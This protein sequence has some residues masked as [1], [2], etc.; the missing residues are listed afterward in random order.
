MKSGFVLTVAVTNPLLLASSST[1]LM[2]AAS[3]L[4][5]MLGCGSSKPLSNRYTFEDKT[6]F[7][8]I[9]KL[10]KNPNDKQSAELLPEAYQAALDKR[11]ETIITEK[12]T[13]SIGDRWME[14]AKEREVT[15]QMYNAIKASPAASKVIPNPHD[16]SAGIQKAKE[17]AAEEYYNQGLENLNYNNRQ[18]AIQA[19]DLFVKADKAVPGYK[20]VKLLSQQALEIGTIKVVVKPVNY[21]RYGWDY[22]GFQNDWL[23]QQMV[24]DLNFGSY[25]DV[26]FFTD[27]EAS[28]KQIRADRIVDLDFT[29]LF[30][31]QVYRDNYTINRSKKIQTG[32]TKTQPPQPVYTTVYAT[33]YVNRQYLESNA[34]LECRIYDWAT[35][36][37]ILY[38]RFPDRYTWKVETATY[39]GDQRA[40]EP[41]DWALINNRGNDYPPGRNQIAERLMRNSY[42]MLLNR[43]RSGVSF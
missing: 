34:T 42:N 11:R 28:S 41:S 1:A 16:P 24:R 14:I 6:V 21:N 18:H 15:L 39:R 2:V 8:L 3:F 20:D 17:R 31:G 37:N 13:G 23:Q 25:R 19:Y 7:E 29:Q 27:W 32:S 12:N 43:I 30:I 4:F 33:V 35:G 5:S 36:R 38:D 26:R 9:E 22:W 40:L 10:N